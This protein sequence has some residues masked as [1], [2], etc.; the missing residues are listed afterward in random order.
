V[1]ARLFSLILLCCLLALPAAARDSAPVQSDNITAR[2]MADQATATPGGAVTLAFVQEIRDG[3]HTYWINPGD[4]GAPANLHWE[5]PEGTVIGEAMWPAPEAIPYYGLMTYGHHDRFVLLFDL[6]L[7]EGW[8]SG[9][10]FPIRLEADWLVCAEICIPEV[11]SFALD[12]ETGASSHPADPA[13]RGL[14]EAARAELPGPSPWTTRFNATAG[15]EDGGTLRLE[16]ALDIELEGL[17]EARF[18]PYTQGLI[19]QVADQGWSIDAEGLTVDMVLDWPE[20]LGATLDGVLVL[21]EDLPDGAL[22]Q[23]FVIEADRDSGL[24]MGGSLLGLT[25]PGSG[26]LGGATGLGDGSGPGLPGPGLGELAFLALI[27]GLLLNLMPCVFPILSIKVLSLVQHAGSPR[28]IAHGLSYTAGVLATFLA[29]AGLL[30]ALQATGALIGWGFQ[31]QEPLVVA[32]LAYLMFVIG[33]WLFSGLDAGMGRLMGLGQGLG[34]N[35]GLGGSFATGVLAVFVASPCTAPFMAGAIGFAMT[36]DAPTALAV[37]AALGLGL[38]LP[39]LASSMSPWVQRRLPRPG[40][41]MVRFRQFMAFP[42]FATAAWLVWVLAQQAGDTALLLVLLGFVAIAMAFWAF[43]LDGRFAKTTGI[44]CLA[45]G[46]GLGVLPGQL[47]AAG[48]SDANR[49][50]GYQ[51]SFEGPA[52]P[53]SQARLAE[54]RDAGRPVLVNMTAA[55]CLTCLVNE[56]NALS[57]ETFRAALARNDAAYLKGDWTRRD[58]AIT[59]YLESFERAGVP[60]YVVYPAAGGEPVLL[61]QL[62]TE[63]MVAGALDRAGNS[64]GL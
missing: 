27:G 52:E 11:G 60:L 59:T 19:D 23:A 42:M 62:L 56:G 28:A 40:P 13:F 20:G 18:F 17:S 5:L 57:G 24:A 30:I 31:L 2:I 6:T 53:F 44:A 48:P 21:T 12:L 4:S 46:L 25:G 43:R 47:P 64:T 33:I 3:W 50:G 61:P 8:P 1:S 38:A 22:R 15:S 34:Q 14:I 26:S 55:W 35:Q 29:L 39:Y 63:G 51:I 36:R 9:T 10:P 58:P 45:L 7:P 16:T 41:W 54:L 37:F 32:F 49:T